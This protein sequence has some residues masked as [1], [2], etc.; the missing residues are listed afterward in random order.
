M[1][2]IEVS[3]VPVG[4]KTASLSRYVAQ[5]VQLLDAEKGI[6]YELTAMGTIIEGDLTQLLE[7]AGKMHR[8]AFTEGVLRVGTNIKIDERRDKPSTIA[9]KVA[10][11]Q[12]KLR[13]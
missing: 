9:G 7:V 5:A 11:V 4:T 10:S 13:E 6:K 2:M 8:A 12:K 1:A 3:V